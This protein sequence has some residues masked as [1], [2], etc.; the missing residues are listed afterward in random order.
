MG[1][2]KAKKPMRLKEC[3]RPALIIKS[4]ADSLMMQGCR[5]PDLI[6]QAEP[7]ASFHP[8]SEGLQHALRPHRMFHPSPFLRAGFSRLLSPTHAG[9]S[10][11]ACFTQC[12]HGT[13]TFLHPFAPRALPRFFATMGALP[14]VRAALRTLIRGNEHR[15]CPEQVSLVHT[16]RP[17]MHSATKHLARPAIAS[18]L[19]TQRD[20]LLGFHPGLDFTLGLQAHRYARPNRVRHYPADC[21]VASGCSPPRLAATQLP[22]TTRERA[23]PEEGTCT[24]QIAPAPRRTVPRQSPGCAPHL[25]LGVM[26]HL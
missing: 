26:G 8:V 11:G 5:P 19:P 25:R 15:P 21:M 20:R 23:S 2:C 3:V 24:P 7:Y 14:P 9:H 1:I 16:A 10:L 4:S 6:N 22:L 13:S 18:P 17:S 12:V